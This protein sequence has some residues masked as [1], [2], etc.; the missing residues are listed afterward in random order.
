MAEFSITMDGF[1]KA[2]DFYGPSFEK[3]LVECARIALNETARWIVS[4]RGP[5]KT[6]MKKNV[7]FPP[8]YIDQADR[9]KISRFASDS[10]LEADVFARSEPTSLARFAVDAGSRNG[11]MVSVKK[12]ARPK[13]IKKGFIW[14]GLKKGDVR[15]GNSGLVI[16]SDGPPDG[17]YRPKKVGDKWPNLWLVYGPSVY[18]VFR[19]S[20]DRFEPQIQ[21]HLAKEFDR[22]IAMRMETS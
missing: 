9:M 2:L 8:G 1:E 21:E 15:R 5:I 12:G 4:P 10:S 22:Q 20:M 18:Q 16:R 17:A 13:M 6:D 14:G 19:Q 3:K 7:N 11:I